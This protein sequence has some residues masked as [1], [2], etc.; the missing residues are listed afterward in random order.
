MDGLSLREPKKHDHLSDA[1]RAESCG[2]CTQ[3]LSELYV[4]LLGARLM[5]ST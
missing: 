5:Q 1:L 2:T 4:E 3:A